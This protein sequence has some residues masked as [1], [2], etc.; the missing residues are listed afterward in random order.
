MRKR[1]KAAGLTQTQLGKL[2]PISQPMVAQI[3]LG[4]EIPSKP[5]AERIDAVLNADRE[6]AQ[7]WHHVRKVTG[8]EEGY[9]AWARRY[10]DAEAR[11]TRIRHFTNVI[12]GL[13]Q[14]EAY[15]RVFIRD[16]VE[17]F[18]TGDLQERVDERIG[19]QKLL[20]GPNAP[21]FWSVLAEEVLHRIIGSHEVMRDQLS[22]LLD[23]ARKPRV[24]FQVLPYDRPIPGG[25]LASGLVS[26]LTMPSGREIAYREDGLSGEFGD[27]P[28]NVAIYNAFYDR[29]QAN[30]LSPDESISL[31]ST[32]LEEEHQ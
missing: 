32:V 21:W 14:T 15:A 31:I 9:P 29:L 18:G 20:D 16:G 12:P 27:R 24:T 22:K 10:I 6:L 3:E 4:N 26:I 8:Q 7:L 28:E 2:I 23:L 1:R 25:V 17:F 5:L 11:A 13:A 30:A 19:R